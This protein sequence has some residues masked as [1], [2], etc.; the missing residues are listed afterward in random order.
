MNE[1]TNKNT[2]ENTN[3]DKKLAVDKTVEFTVTKS[4]N[5]ARLSA[6]VAGLAVVGAAVYAA[7]RF[8]GG[9]TDSTESTESSDGE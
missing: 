6:Y 9:S 3:P 8:F 1:E 4:I 2:S 7:L 5:W